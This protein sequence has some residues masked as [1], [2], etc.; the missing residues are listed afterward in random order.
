MQGGFFKRGI[1]AES[2]I[3]ESY[4]IK[5]SDII[6]ACS[7]CNNDADVG[8]ELETELWTPLENWSSGSKDRLIELSVGSKFS[9]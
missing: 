7:N 5:S 3:A 1:I 2:G 9:S 6:G 8:L 4:T